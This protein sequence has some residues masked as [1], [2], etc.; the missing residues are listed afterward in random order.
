MLSSKFKLKLNIINCEENYYRSPKYI[1]R[2][3]KMMG[4]ED[5]IFKKIEN[6]LY[7][8]REYSKENHS[9]YNNLN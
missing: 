8:P 7:L 1:I 4:K 3:T 2:Q 6:K 9:F 5:Q